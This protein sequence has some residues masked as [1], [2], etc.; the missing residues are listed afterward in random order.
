MQKLVRFV[1]GIVLVIAGQRSSAQQTRETVIPPRT[2]RVTVV[3]RPV[4]VQEYPDSGRFSVT[5][6]TPILVTAETD[7]LGRAFARMLAPAFGFTLRVLRDSTPANVRP[8]VLTIDDEL[9]QLLGAEGYELQVTARQIEVRAA[10]RAGAFYG[11]QTL[12]QLLPPRVFSRTRVTG[13][14]WSVPAVEIVDYPRFSWRGTHLDVA[15]H[16]MPVT[17]VKKFIDLLA[18]HKINRFH[19]HL[20]DD[21]GWRLEIKRYPRLTSVGAWRR[22]T[23]IGRPRG[24]STRW[25][26]DRKRHGGFYTQDQVRDVVRYAAERFITVV[27]EIEMPG[28]AQAAIAAYPELGVTGD[29]IPV[30]TR[31]GVSKNILNAEDSTVR[32]MQ[33]VLEEVLELFPSEFIHIGGDEADKAFWATSPRIQARIRELGFFGEAQLQSWFIKQMDTFLTERGRRLIGWDEILEG[34]LA[35]GAAVMSWRGYRGGIAA[36]KEGHDVV[37]APTRYTYFDFYPTRDTAREP[38]AIGN[39]LPIDSVYSFEPIPPE[40]SPDEARHVLGAQAQHWT[41]YMPNSRQVEYMAF[42]RLGA[43]AEVVWTPSE[44]KDLID[45]KARLPAYL[46]R[47]R[48]YGVNYR[49]PRPNDASGVVPRR[50]R[51]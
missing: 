46:S 41:E 33:N 5:R 17:F 2:P 15:R 14:T 34:G 43:L 1:T 25:R 49:A 28:H 36:A 26:Y 31:W 4:H 10:G 45:F 51:R 8:I 6:R 30:W 47:L 40:L 44:R 39:F 22:Q 27:P 13:V 12:R 35:P 24:D 11:L 32:F 48:S 38:L 42:P 29:T 18:A 9:R 23:I 7:S 21:Q 20:T 50:R 3:P 16:F 37:M 19:W